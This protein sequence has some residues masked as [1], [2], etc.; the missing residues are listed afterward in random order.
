VSSLFFLWGF[1]D[2]LI[3]TLNTQIQ[4]LLGYSDS[5]RIALQGAY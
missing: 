2:G 1:A 3:D 5:Q 4:S